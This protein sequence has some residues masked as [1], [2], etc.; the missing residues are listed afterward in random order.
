[1]TMI[2]DGSNGVTFNDASL[3]GAAASPNVLK[4]R[5]INGAMVIDQRNAGASVTVNTGS[6]YFYAV[7]R[8]LGV[9]QVSD[10][11]FT[12]QQNTSVPTGQGFV[13]SIKATITTA[14]ASIGA[15]QQYF[16]AQTIEGYN[17]ADLQ[18]GTANAKTVTLSFWVNCSVTGTFSG[19]FM[20]ENSDRSYPFTYTISVANTWEQKTITIAGDTTGTW[21]TTNGLGLSVQW[22]LGSGSSRS[23]TANTW[24]AARYHGATGATTLIS[25]LSATFYITGVQLEVGSTA[26][27]FER[28]LYNQEL[29]NCQRY[30]YMHARGV[31]QV[32]GNGYYWS[33]S[34]FDSIFSYPVTMRAIPTLDSSTGTNF[35]GAD[36]TNGTNTFN[37]WTAQGTTPQSVNIYNASASGTSGVAGGA[38]TLTSGAYVALN[39]EL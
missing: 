6:Q 3:Q 39:A 35:Y 31:S 21:A 23:G 12:M 7:D 1:M 22:S 33:S 20:N 32:I 13:N 19:C 24:A 26:T 10:G 27:P 37:S 2:L 9:G 28:R 4:N 29:A 30:Y 36:R 14:D 38:R 11:V 16:I 25:T 34:E 15:T 8:F 18:Y 17:V 5:I